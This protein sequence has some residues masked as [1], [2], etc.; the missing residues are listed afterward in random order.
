[1]PGISGGGALFWK[2]CMKLDVAAPLV[3][4]S[5]VVVLPLYISITDTSLTSSTAIST[6]HEGQFRFQQKIQVTLKSLLNIKAHGFKNLP[7]NLY[8]VLDKLSNFWYVAARFNHEHSPFLV[9]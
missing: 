7:W 8:G 9:C 5:F 4:R 6:Q 2:R 3:I 1:M